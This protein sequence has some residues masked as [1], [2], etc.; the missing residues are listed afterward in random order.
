MEHFGEL[1]C[2]Y[3][4]SWTPYNALAHPLLPPT[5]CTLREFIARPVCHPT[6]TLRDYTFVNLSDYL[7]VAVNKTVTKSKVINSGR[8]G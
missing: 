5:L 1:Y 2:L 6:I 3:Q 8:K 7:H 4:R